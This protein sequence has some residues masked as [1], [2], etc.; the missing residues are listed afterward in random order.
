MRRRHPRLLEKRAEVALV[1]RIAEGDLAARI[2]DAAQ[3][4]DEQLVRELPRLA[5][6]ADGVEDD[7]LQ[8]LG[9]RRGAAHAECDREHDEEVE[10]LEEVDHGLSALDGRR[11][12]V[13][14]RRRGG[15]NVDVDLDLHTAFRNEVRDLAVQPSEHASVRQPR[16]TDRGDLLARGQELVLRHQLLLLGFVGLVVDEPHHG[17]ARLVKRDLT[18]AHRVQDRAEL[19]VRCHLEN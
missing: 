8:K 10:R 16:G 11:E 2:L 7:E 4:Q 12:H 13:G 18:R 14:G 5:P 1:H 6:H 3:H 15:T 17:D 9:D 19:G